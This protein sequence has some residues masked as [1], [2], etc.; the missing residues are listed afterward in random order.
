LRA[1]VIAIVES[2]KRLIANSEGRTIASPLRN[3]TLT[4]LIWFRNT[5]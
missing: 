4:E 1:V 5:N 2:P 3:L